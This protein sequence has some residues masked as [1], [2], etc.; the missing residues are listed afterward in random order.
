MNNVV[1]DFKNA[2][3]DL[4]HYEAWQMW[5]IGAIGLALMFVGYKIKRVAFF[6]IWFLLGYIGTGY[7]LPIIN[8]NLPDIAGSSFWQGLIPILG[9]L[10]LGLMG[11]MVEKICIAG[12]TFGLTIM[13]TAQ[14]FGTEMQPMII[15]AI[16]GAVLAGFATMMIK[17]ATIVATAVAGAYALTLAV[18]AIGSSNL[19]GSDLFWPMIIGFSALGSV[20]QFM[21]TRHDL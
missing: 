13:M 4:S 16:I 12:V 17:P 1:E 9:G 8:G 14:Y 20:V 3:L 5:L 19:N 6:I 18:L 21:T 10:L 11:F 2:K 15:G 7:L